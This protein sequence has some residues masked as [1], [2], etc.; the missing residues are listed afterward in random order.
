[1]KRTFEL[2]VQQLKLRI[3]RIARDEGLDSDVVVAAL[4]D[5]LGVTAA[6][7]DMQVGPHP[8]EDRLDSFIA[9]VKDQHQSITARASSIRKLG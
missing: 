6:T 8:I 3:L 9:R 4:A 2:E 1:M 7:L 5:V